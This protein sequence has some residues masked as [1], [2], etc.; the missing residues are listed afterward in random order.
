MEKVKTKIDNGDFDIDNTLFLPF[1]N[2]SDLLRKVENIKEAHKIKFQTLIQ[3]LK[4][5][6]IKFTPIDDYGVVID[7]S[8]LSDED[9][10]LITNQDN[11]LIQKVYNENGVIAHLKQLK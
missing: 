8:L 9:I 5:N 1:D 3:M 10:K 6:E 11:S 7:V 2:I 4:Q